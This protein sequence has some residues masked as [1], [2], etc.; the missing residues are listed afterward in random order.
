MSMDPNPYVVEAQRTEN[1]RV[2]WGKE[3]WSSHRAKGP[4]RVVLVV[5]VGGVPGHLLR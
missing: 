1:L 4:S 3:D 5:E 2:V